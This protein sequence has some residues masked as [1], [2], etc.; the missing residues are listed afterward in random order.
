MLVALDL[1][2]GGGALSLLLVLAGLPWSALA[3][4]SY[5]TAFTVLLCVSA[6]A[7]VAAHAWW[8]RHEEQQL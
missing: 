2:V 3:L 1:V 4:G 6:V 7:N 5:G 8:L